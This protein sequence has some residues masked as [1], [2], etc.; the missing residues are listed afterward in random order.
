M[1]VKALILDVDYR[2]TGTCSLGSDSLIEKNFGYRPLHLKSALAVKRLLDNK[3][4]IEEEEDDL[5]NYFYSVKGEYED[6]DFIVVDSLTG[7]QGFEKNDIR[8]NRE[9]FTLQDWGRLAERMHNFIVKL[10]CCD[11]NVIFISHTKQ[12][13]DSEMGR[14]IEVPALSG[15]IG[16]SIGRY[17]DMILYSVI[18][19]TP[20]KKRLYKWQVIP[21]E[22]R[23]ARSL[24]S[25]TEYAES[26]RGLLDQD[27]KV[28]FD[29]IRKD[30]DGPVKIGIF[31]QYG[32]GKTYSL[33][34]LMSL[35]SNENQ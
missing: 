21:D 34:T 2:R 8:G 6:T 28:L 31:G 35:N 33:K 11:K 18:V 16:E 13:Q 17:L 27:Y 14:L 20:Q 19:T 24:P 12:V 25:I 4:I 32:T 5:G 23:N 1:A 26:K 29:L 7:L 10:A 30:F 3:R 22:R 9:L 15:Q